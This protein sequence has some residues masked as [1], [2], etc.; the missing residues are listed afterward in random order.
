MS[1]L[2]EVLL[3][4]TLLVMSAASVR[5]ETRVQV[6]VAAEARVRVS[7]AAEARALRPVAAGSI[8]VRYVWIGWIQRKKPKQT[9]DCYKIAARVGTEGPITMRAML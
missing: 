7:V 8:V 6:P 1:G 3:T 9:K 4:S 2:V 5:A